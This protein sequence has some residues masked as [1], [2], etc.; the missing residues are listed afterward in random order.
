MKHFVFNYLNA[1]IAATKDIK[2]NVGKIIEFICSITQK[3]NEDIEPRTFSGDKQLEQYV[4]PQKGM[5]YFGGE[6]PYRTIP[7][8]E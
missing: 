7:C 2:I 4:L 8:V 3:D 6:N 5:F 1:I